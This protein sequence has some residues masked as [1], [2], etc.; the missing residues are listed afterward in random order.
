MI[1]PISHRQAGE[2]T[3]NASDDCHM[4]GTPHQETAVPNRQEISS[5]AKWL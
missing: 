4:A 1:R 5:G 2:K 3:E